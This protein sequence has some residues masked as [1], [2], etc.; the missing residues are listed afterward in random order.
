M[1][2]LSLVINYNYYNAR[3]LFPAADGC[4]ET[5][6][7]TKGVCKIK[8]SPVQ[9]VCSRAVAFIAH[10]KSKYAVNVNGSNCINIVFA[11]ACLA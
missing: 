10:A 6:S 7:K 3:V 9:S 2:I 1:W 4:V 11:S 8:D 5:C